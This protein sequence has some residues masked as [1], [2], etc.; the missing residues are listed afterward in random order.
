MAAHKKVWPRTRRE[1]HFSIKSFARFDTEDGHEQ[2]NKDHAEPVTVQVYRSAPTVA[3][4]LF[5]GFRM[6]TV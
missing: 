6:G 4:S 1:Q 5:R 3:L 2:V